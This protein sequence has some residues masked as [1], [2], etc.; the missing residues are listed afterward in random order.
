LLVT[1]QADAGRLV[2]QSSSSLYQR[3]RI[4]KSPISGIAQASNRTR[5]FRTTN[6]FHEQIARLAFA[7]SLSS[8]NN[9]MVKAYK[10][11]TGIL[12]FAAM[13]SAIFA[14]TVS[15]LSKN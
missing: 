14:V 1:R 15:F 8:R 11:F 6:D 9:R 5:V 10:A 2:W 3:H 12:L 7:T 13:P 4:S